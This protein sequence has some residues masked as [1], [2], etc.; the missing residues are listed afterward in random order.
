MFSSAR[1]SPPLPNHPQTSYSGK[2]KHRLRD[3]GSPERNVL[4]AGPYPQP[5]KSLIYNPTQETT[6]KQQEVIFKEP[7]ATGSEY[8]GSK[9][10]PIKVQQ[11]QKNHKGTA[12]PSGGST[13]GGGG[14]RGR[15]PRRR[16][17]KERGKH[18]TGSSCPVEHKTWQ[19]CV[20]Q[21]G[22]KEGK[23]TQANSIS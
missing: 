23:K 18:Q 3:P 9:H 17:R 19:F 22:G 11:L 14:V 6:G 8:R 10:V 5:G 1:M 21:Q 16:R 12:Y 2:R 4:T 15:G 7:V 13:G 20:A